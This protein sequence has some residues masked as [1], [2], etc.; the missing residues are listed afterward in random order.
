MNE[1][2]QAVDVG[3]YRGDNL[4]CRRIALDETPERTMCDVRRHGCREISVGV[5]N[6]LAS[7]LVAV[8]HSDSDQY[9]LTLAG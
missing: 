9:F 1:F 5:A 7:S 2:L 6:Y 3:I 8:G 4:E